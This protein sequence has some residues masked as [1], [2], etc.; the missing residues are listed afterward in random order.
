MI[1]VYK[2]TTDWGDINIPNGWYYL[3][4]SNYLVAYKNNDGVYKKFK[5]PIKGF[6]KARRKFALVETIPEE[7]DGDVI[8]VTGSKGD[9][10]T[11]I[12]GKCSCNGF[13][14]RRSCKHVKE[15]K[16]GS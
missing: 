5:K 2:E 14:F 7:S 16:S 13:K 12:N 6:S 11:I 4:N 10:Y 8:T 3:N 1:K 9:I 15:N